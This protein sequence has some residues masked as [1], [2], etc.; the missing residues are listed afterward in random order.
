[1]S[2]AGRMEEATALHLLS[3]Q[4]RNLQLVLSEQMVLV[5]APPAVSVSVPAEA[6]GVTHLMF[7]K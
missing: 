3:W 6:L 2:W 1:M 7:K 4:G 5:S